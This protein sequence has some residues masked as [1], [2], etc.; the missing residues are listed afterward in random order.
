[1]RLVE[2]TRLKAP[3]YVVYFRSTAV[4]IQRLTSLQ[5][6]YCEDVNFQGVCRHEVVPARKCMNLADRWDN[7]I[8]SFRPD[9]ASG[10][11]RW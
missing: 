8:S 11:G 5:V 2:S 10:G 6:Y 4:P 3:A 7:N 1:M 9:H